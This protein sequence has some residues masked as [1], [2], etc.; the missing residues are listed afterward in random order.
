MGNVEV[1]NTRTAIVIV[2]LPTDKCA[3]RKERPPKCGR[4]TCVVCLDAY[5]RC[6]RPEKGEK[7]RGRPLR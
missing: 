4:K 6:E 3:E 7:A 5:Q 1:G 2:D